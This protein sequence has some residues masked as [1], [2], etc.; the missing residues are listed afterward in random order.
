MQQIGKIVEQRKLPM[1]I[2]ATDVSTDDVRIALELKK[3]ADE[4]KVM[5]YLFKN[6]QLQVNFAVNLTCLIPTE[7]EEIGRP[8]RC[9]LREILKHFLDFRLEVVTKRLEFELSNLTKRI[10]ILEGLKVVF[11][12]LD[13]IIA[14]IRAS[15]GK[16][17]AATKIMAEFPL[18]AEQTD[19]ILE[20][21]LYRLARLEINLIADELKRKQERAEEIRKLLGDETAAG[22]WKIVRDELEAVTKEHGDKRRTLID[23]GAEQELE[24]SEADFIVDEDTMV[25]LTTDGWIKRQKDIRDPSTTRLR[26]G[27]SVLAALAGST[28]SPVAF[29]SNLG[30]CYTCRMIDIEVSKGYGEPIQKLFKLKDGERIV[31]AYSLDPRAIG[32]IVTRLEGHPP[33]VHALAATSDGL[34]MRFSLEGFTEPST[35]NGRK[36]AKASGKDAEIIGVQTVSG[37][38]H[39]LAATLQARVIRCPVAEINFLSGPG[40]GVQLIRLGAGDRVLGFRALAS[41]RQSLRVRTES[42]SEKA[43]TLGNTPAGA[44]GGRGQEVLKR[45]KFAAVL[46]EPVATPEL[47]EPR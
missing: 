17:D 31:A 42:G 46:A 21:K 15:E 10:H 5:A 36:Y 11:D 35:R 19:A 12:A 33:P 40:K 26:E 20:L 1:L 13:R 29:F 27:D 44:R 34:A 37:Q 2:D 24:Y 9:D 30:A 38:E 7:N 23:A 4:Q 28:R 18:D 41:E 14:I 32:T 43:F 47:R 16:Q 3:D 39:V 8:E 25:I 45:G 22:R 6:T